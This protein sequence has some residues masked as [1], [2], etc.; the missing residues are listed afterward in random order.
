MSWLL[1][2][3]S[4][5]DCCQTARGI[6]MSTLK[7]PLVILAVANVGIILGK[8]PGLV[9]DKVKEDQV[10]PRIYSGIEAV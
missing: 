5:R 8:L 4:R 9:K 7:G 3:E 10:L 6:V 2:R 1:I